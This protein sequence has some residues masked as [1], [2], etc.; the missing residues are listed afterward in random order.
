MKT[1][2]IILTS[3]SVL[4]V[5]GMGY[6]IYFD[7]RRRTDP[8]FRKGLKKE[9]K[10]LS[11]VEKKEAAKRAQ[12]ED[13]FIQDLLQEVR[14][15][16]I[17]PA[18]VEEREQYFLKYVSLG[19][20]LFAM[21]TDKYLEAAAAFYKA[22]KVYPQ[23]VELIM[24][25]EKTVPKEVFDTIM[26]IVSKE[27][28][29]GGGEGQE[30]MT[31]AGLDEVD[32]DGPSPS[33][34]AAAK[35]AQAE[36]DDDDED[37][38]KTESKEASASTSAK[39]AQQQG[40][41]SG[42]TSSQE[43]DTLSATSLN[44]TG[45]MVTPNAPASTAS[46]SPESSAALSAPATAEEEETATAAETTGEPK[47]TSIDTSASLTKEPVSTPSKQNFTSGWSPAPVFSGSSPRAE[48]KVD[49]FSGGQDNSE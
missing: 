8:A 1:S 48:K 46:E 21:G 42:T 45:V 3:L 2:Q 43:W 25:Y 29:T 20:Q 14:T 27:I 44:E 17:F 40:T 5:A 38:D 37:D 11:K 12:Q 36:D 9:S 41:D 30:S 18:G 23:R 15:P 16:G 35:K 32:D 22:S 49:P 28:A 6:A 19:E 10:K 31:A 47:L 26:R 13:G 24:I 39:P 33:A 34:A 4:G 7:H